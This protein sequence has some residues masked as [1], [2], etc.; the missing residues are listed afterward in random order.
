M[1]QLEIA[2]AC[3][4]ALKR[5]FLE[6]AGGRADNAAL[7]DIK[8]LCLGAMRAV[9]DAVCGGTLVAIHCCAA[10]LYSDSA[11]RHWDRGPAPGVDVLRR[12]I[13]RALNAYQRRLYR[14]ERARVLLE[15]GGKA[16]PARGQPQEDSFRAESDPPPPGGRPDIPA[17]L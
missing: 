6:R 14:L 9:D 16:L 3:R 1:R 10:A 2:R 12:K 17:G 13:F 4:A 7:D 11:H 5:I 8:E 15:D